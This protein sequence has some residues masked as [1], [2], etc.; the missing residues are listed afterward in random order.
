MKNCG[1]CGTVLKE[2]DGE[3]SYFSDEGVKIQVCSVCFS[4]L[5]HKDYAGNNTREDGSSE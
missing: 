2:G 5:K 3:F 4:R 1:V